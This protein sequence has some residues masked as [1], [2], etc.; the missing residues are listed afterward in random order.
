MYVIIFTPPINLK[1][2][3]P[4]G[5]SS[6]DPISPAPRKFQLRAYSCYQLRGCNGA[7][8]HFGSIR[9]A[10]GLSIDDSVNHETAE[11]QLPST[12]GTV[13]VIS[14]LRLRTA[15]VV[16]WVACLSSWLSSL[17]SIFQH[18]SARTIYRVLSKANG[19][20]Q[21]SFLGSYAG[22]ALGPSRG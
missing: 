5:V 18:G 8:S 7:T 15:T 1:P 9:S 12:I 2:T 11:I 22:T 20:S 17:P 13:A 6:F 10:L 14:R 4:N 16:T 3:K 21:I 19:N